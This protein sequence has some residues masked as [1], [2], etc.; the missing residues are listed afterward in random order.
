MNSTMRAMAFLFLEHAEIASH[1]IT[2]T[3][4]LSWWESWL[5]ALVFLLL[6]P[7]HFVIGQGRAMDGGHIK[8]LA[9]VPWDWQA[10]HNLPQIHLVSALLVLACTARKMAQH[11]F[12][13]AFWGT[14]LISFGV[15]TVC[16][17]SCAL[18][19]TLD[20]SY[21]LVKAWQWRYIQRKSI[22]LLSATSQL[23]ASFPENSWTPKLVTNHV[24]RSAMKNTVG[25]PSAPFDDAL[26][27]THACNVPM[28][29]SDC[30]THCRWTLQPK[31]AEL[32]T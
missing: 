22:I 7:G 16:C 29:R 9:L 31:A 17:M 10:E 1:G 26:W 3:Q 32:Y 27:S 19:A 14:R 24:R 13:L 30:G 2:K 25:V 15:N 11:F 21:V 6:C 23:M 8:V 5:L 20:T 18:D 12:F 4:C 28:A